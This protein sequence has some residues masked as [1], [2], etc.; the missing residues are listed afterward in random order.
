M[1]I[2]TFDPDGSLGALV[3]ASLI[4]AGHRVSVESDA[5]TAELKLETA[6][7]DCVVACTSGM[8]ESLATYLETEWPVLP[9]VLAGVENEVAPAGSILAVL[10]RPLSMERLAAVIRR[11]EN[12]LAADAAKTYDMPIDVIAGEQRLACRVIR[13]AHGSVMLEGADGLEG[14]LALQR[15]SVSL[16]ANV[17]FRDRGLVAVRVDGFEQLEEVWHAEGNADPSCGRGLP[18]LPE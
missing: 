18:D 10:A 4:S 17:V 6:L 2:L 14:P 8:P 1:N 3:R 15:G 11:I 9:V 12:K 5:T 7:F 13:V 16:D